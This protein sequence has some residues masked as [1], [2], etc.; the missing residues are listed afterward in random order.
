M[1]YGLVGDNFSNGGI[2]RLEG[3]NS[4]F[5]NNIVDCNA[6]PWQNEA[7]IEI[8]KNAGLEPQYKYLLDEL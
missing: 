7:A 2:Y 4:I 5:K 6:P 3:V 8:I 1:R